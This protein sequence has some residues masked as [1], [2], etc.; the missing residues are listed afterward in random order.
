MVGV[1]ISAHILDRA[2]SPVRVTRAT[3]LEVIQNPAYPSIIAP[4][5]MVAARRPAPTLA[6]PLRC[7][8]VIQAIVS[9]WTIKAA[10]RST[11]APLPTVDATR[12]VRLQARVLVPARVQLDTP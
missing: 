11:T 1:L 12:R 5:L 8:R 9:T 3:I 7:A 4:R 2:L 6:Q 10:P